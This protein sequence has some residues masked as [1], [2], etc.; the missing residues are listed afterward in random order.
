MRLLL[1]HLSQNNVKILRLEEYLRGWHVAEHVDRH[2]RLAREAIQK[3][4]VVFYTSEH[5]GIILY[6]EHEFAGFKTILGQYY[7]SKKWVISTPGTNSKFGDRHFLNKD[8]T[9]D[10]IHLNKTMSLN[11]IVH[12]DKTKDFLFLNGKSTPVRLKL[13]EEM[14]NNG[15]LANSVWSFGDSQLD[16]ILAPMY[17]WPRWQ[18]KHIDFYC[19]ETRKVHPLQ[20]TDTICSVVAE[21]LVD[22]EIHYISEKTFKPLAAGHLFVILSGADFLKNLRERGFKTF[23]DHFDESYD[24]EPQLD[25]RI[26]KIISLLKFIR[27]CDYKK[28]YRDTTDI[29]NHNHQ[30]MLDSASIDIFN[31]SKCAEIM[32]YFP[33]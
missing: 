25:Q 16:N 14:R 10:F 15:L 17:E 3:H 22:N 1:N 29:R 4:N 18:G 23:H 9:A 28:L 19:V 12:E 8:N 11:D 13:A 6:P 33:K 26:K 24:T 30:L 20:Y 31:T 2:I 27:T 5:T 7:D 32:S 21:T